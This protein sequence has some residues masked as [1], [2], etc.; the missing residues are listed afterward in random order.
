MLRDILISIVGSFAK[1]E[2]ESL[3]LRTKAGLAR[4]RAEGKVL[5]RPKKVFDRE[6]FN[7]VA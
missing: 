1:Q 5:G 6:E 2:R 4:E 3:I 7:E